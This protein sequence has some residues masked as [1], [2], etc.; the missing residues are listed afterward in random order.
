[1]YQYIRSFYARVN[2]FYPNQKIK[3]YLRVVSSIFLVIFWYFFSRIFSIFISKNK[4]EYIFV[5]EQNAYLKHY[6]SLKSNNH[7]P[8]YT[9]L[10]YSKEKLNLI[11]KSVF[12]TSVYKKVIMHILKTRSSLRILICELATSD[13]IYFV[14]VANLLGSKISFVQHSEIIF[15]NYWKN[16]MPFISN[17]YI[18]HQFMYRYLKENYSIYGQKMKICRELWNLNS[19]VEKNPEK[20]LIYV[21]QPIENIENFLKNYGYNLNHIKKIIELNFSDIV[22]KCKK[23]NLKFIY[24]KHPREKF[25]NIPEFVRNNSQ[26]KNNDQITFAKSDLVYSYF[27]SMLLELSILGIKCNFLSKDYKNTIFEKKD[28]LKL[29]N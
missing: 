13:S 11:D 1:M 16:F 18:R 20:R 28:F 12:K 19:I 8:N 14:K 21:G 15:T 4:T 6:E 17:F 9:K 25:L 29:L 7:I 27:S 10:L 22:K 5:C 26:I 24:L 3:N 23:E 2:Y